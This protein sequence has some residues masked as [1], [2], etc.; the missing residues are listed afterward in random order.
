MTIR[1]R[2]TL[3]VPGLL[4]KHRLS[5]ERPHLALI[6]PSTQKDPGA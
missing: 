6:D 1:P 5:R 4:Q 3:G 2:R